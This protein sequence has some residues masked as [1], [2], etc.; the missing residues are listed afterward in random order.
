[1]NKIGIDPDLMRT[2]AREYH[3]E[4]EEIAMVIGRLDKLLGKLESEWDGQASEAY[5]QRY[6][7]L[8]KGFVA[9]QELAEEI[10]VALTDVAEHYQE[11]DKAVARAV[12]G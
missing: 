7:E 10:G 3:K 6:V 1:M 5:R 11:T 8:K 4:S 2:R 9:A 12:R